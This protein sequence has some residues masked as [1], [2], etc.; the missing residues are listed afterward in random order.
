MKRLISVII[1][2]LM[3]VTA[4]PLCATAAG[5]GTCPV[6]LTKPTNATLQWLLGDDS[7][8]TMNFTYTQP[9][10]VRDFAAAS[11]RAI[12]E[13]TWDAFIAAT[14]YDD[15]IITTQIDWAIDDPTDWKY[16]L[17]PEAWNGEY[18]FG[19]NSDSEYAV[20]PWSYPDDGWVGS[21]TTREEWVLRGY[22]GEYSEW[23]DHEDWTGRD[24]KPGLRDVLKAGQYSTDGDGLVIDWEEH[25]A[26]VRVRYVVKC[27]YWENDEYKEDFW[28]SEW[29]DPAAYGKDAVV[30]EPPVEGDV[31]APV[32]SNFRMTDEEFNDWPVIAYTLDVPDDF[33]ALVTEVA[34][35]RGYS[36]IETFCRELGKGGEWISIQGDRTIRAGE[37]KW[38]LVTL[39][40]T[41][42][43]TEYTSLELK[44][45]YVVEVVFGETEYTLYSDFSNVLTFKGKDV[46]V[47]IVNTADIFDDIS[48]GNWFTEYVDYAYSYGLMNGISDSRF[49]PN[50]TMT[51]AML[52]TVLWR[53]EG[54]PGASAPSPFKDL[55][56]DWYSDAVA[57]AYENEIVNGMSETKFAPNNPLTREQ[58]AAIIYRY[59]SFK[60]NDVS[61]EADITKYPD[62]KTVHDWAVV[63]MKWAV[64]EG[65]ITGVRRGDKD[66]LEP[67]ANATRAQVAA[68]LK[69]YLER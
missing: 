1:C 10:G 35:H 64:A 42:E 45:R 60:G 27:P 47:T 11:E 59:S 37:N 49:N 34:G 17:C 16:D 28:Y 29:S 46:P 21:E 56:A 65:L 53:V 54:A 12:E 31:P 66:Y 19:Y 38:D 33:L 43:M 14:G 52:V 39:S 55:T 3:L 6:E 68:I 25:T 23:K 30:W 36:Y 57:W 18:G 48:E 26:Y 8:T 13:E 20:D 7:P 5:R 61:K 69:R 32:I 24:A 50:G 58:I 67:R 22:Y 44:T 4:L 41:V 2:V 9:E 62:C 15:V 63:N 40:G 51:R